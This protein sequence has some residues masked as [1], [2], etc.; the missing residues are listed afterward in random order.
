MCLFI[1]LRGHQK[2][3]C[4][5]QNTHL[6]VLEV[7]IYGILKLPKLFF[8]LHLFLFLVSSHTSL[9][10]IFIIIIIVLFLE[11]QGGGGGGGRVGVRYLKKESKTPIDS[12]S[13]VWLVTA[14]IYLPLSQCLLTQMLLVHIFSSITLVATWLD[15]TIPWVTPFFFHTLYS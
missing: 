12:S 4:S 10:I 8:L 15:F 6:V 13:A 14:A 11:W 5:S 7:V 1:K 2:A 3:I 9:S